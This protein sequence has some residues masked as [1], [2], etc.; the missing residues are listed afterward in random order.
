MDNNNTIV[1]TEHTK[2]L[3]ITLSL[4]KC[5]R[6]AN[7]FWFR[8][9]KDIYRKRPVFLQSSYWVLLPSSVSCREVAPTDCWKLRWLGIQ[10]VQMKRGPPWWFVGLVVLVQETFILH[11]LLWS[12][13]FKQIFPSLYTVSIYV[14]QHW[15]GSHA[16]P[17]VSECVSPAESASMVLHLP[18]LAVLLSV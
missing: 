18:S 14:P 13:E 11:W 4:S 2:T 15:A 9:L 17:P 3:H 6:K 8:L 10:R 5:F 12:V 16:G 1:Y 7:T